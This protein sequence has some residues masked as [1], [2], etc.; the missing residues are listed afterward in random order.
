[1]NALEIIYLIGALAVGLIIGM[2]VEMMIDA[3]TIRDLQAHNRKLRLENAQLRKEP[4]VIEI[5]DN[6]SD[7]DYELPHYE[8][9]VDFSQK[10]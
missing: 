10:W 8:D 2:V 6:R 7:S 3:G 1:M 9:V 5:F 4:E